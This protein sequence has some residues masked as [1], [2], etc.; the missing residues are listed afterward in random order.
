MFIKDR[1]N[2]LFVT[3]IILATASMLAGFVTRGFITN[4]MYISTF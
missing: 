3:L 1:L 4:N 2:G